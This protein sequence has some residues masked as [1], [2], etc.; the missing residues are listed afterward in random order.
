MSPPH[1][2]VRFLHRV[3]VHAAGSGVKWLKMLSSDICTPCHSSRHAGQDC[4]TMSVWIVFVRA[5]S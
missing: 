2:T 3:L 1:P 5:Q 4:H